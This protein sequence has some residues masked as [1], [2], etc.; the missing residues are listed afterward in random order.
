[1]TDAAPRHPRRARS[2]PPDTARPP[3]LLY[4]VGRRPDPLVLPPWDVSGAE[5]F[6]D[7]RRQFRVLYAAERRLACFIETLAHFRPHVA[8]LAQLHAA[9]GTLPPE[10]GRVPPDWNQRRLVGR[11]RLAERQRWLDL[12]SPRTCELLRVELAE[13]LIH[14][15]LDDLDVSGVRG[16]SRALTQAIARWAFERGFRGIAYRSRFDD[17]L[18]CWAVF[19][20][21]A[22]VAAGPPE[23]IS[24]RD[25]DL[26]AAA[27][28]FGLRLGRG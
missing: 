12:R 1:M 11:F 24:R 25:P 26:R 3:D 27:R 5:R 16:P 17:A 14:L 22:W 2:R 28:L 13:V 20:N 21:A 6:D 15:G 7:P 19:E 23:L 9:G 18:T 4:R 10:A 8:V